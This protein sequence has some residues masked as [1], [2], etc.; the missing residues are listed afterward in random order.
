[1]AICLTLRDATSRSCPPPDAEKPS[2][3]NG[4]RSKSSLSES[5][6]L[7]LAPSHLSF[8]EPLTFGSFHRL[9]S[10]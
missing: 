10:R 6:R 9:Y 5:R 1:M 3:N 8:Q 7:A 4:N 2:S